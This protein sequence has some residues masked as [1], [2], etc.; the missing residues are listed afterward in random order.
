MKPRVYPVAIL[1]VVLFGLASGLAGPAQAQ[2]VGSIMGNVYDQN[3]RPLSGVRIAAR[4]ETQIGGE[5]TTYTNADGF[6]RLPGLQ[7]GRFEVHATAPRLKTLLQKDV[8]VGVNAPAE[9]NLLM[10]VEAGTEEVKVVEKAPIVSTTSAT[11]KEV[12]DSDFVDQLPMDKRTGYGGFIRDTVPGAS[13]A[14]D[15]TARV[16]GG[17]SQ[18]NGI[19]VEGFHMANQKITLNSLAAMEVQ[20]AGY[21]AENAGY[22]G[23]V[24]NMVTKSGSNNYELDVG[25]F[26][27]DSRLRPFLES[28]EA[29][30]GV[31]NT[32]FNPAVSG[33]I[34][35]DRLWF[36]FNFESRYMVEDRGEDP[37]G[38]YDEPPRSYYGNVRGTLKL[39][40][41]V[42]PATRCRPSPWSTARRTRTIA[43]AS[44][45][46][47]RPSA[48]ASGTT[49]LPGSPGSRCS[50]I[51]SSS[52]PSWATSAS[53]GPTCRRCAGPTR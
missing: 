17:N 2:V 50:P 37:S 47:P 41:Q 36:Y 26:H 7:P 27:E 42:T 34:L 24:V 18:Q 12:F 35:R 25:A 14:G 9:V 51:L 22:P 8:L 5:R 23:S 10:D 45:W 28:N 43:T 30:P 16:R 3:G 44:T 38:S 33:P 46:L 31:T 53:C 49:T 32:F 4:S 40:W 21:G 48:C 52:R 29:N 20:T 19:L 13:N 6:F 39:T 1:T 15:W 11:V